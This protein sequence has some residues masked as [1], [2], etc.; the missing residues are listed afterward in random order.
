MCKTAYNLIVWTWKFNQCIF[1]WKHLR[2]SLT[3]N[4]LSQRWVWSCWQLSSAAKSL[5]VSCRSLNLAVCLAGKNSGKVLEKEEVGNNALAYEERII[6]VFEMGGTQRRDTFR[7]WCWGNVSPATCTNLH[8]H[9]KSPATLR[10]NLISAV[11]WS[12]RPPPR[13]RDRSWGSE[14]WHRP[15]NRVRLFA[16]Q[17]FLHHSDPVQRL[18]YH[19]C[20]SRPPRYLNS[21]TWGSSPPCLL[22]WEQ[23]TSEE[24][25][26][27]SRE[28]LHV[29]LKLTLTLHVIHPVMSC[30]TNTHLHAPSWE[31]SWTMKNHFSLR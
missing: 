13:A 4:F 3:Q 26:N 11:C 14:R 7:R 21:L 1:L 29:L 8:P 20:G 6:L 9:T 19:R 18:H 2:L 10:R 25:E 22:E 28:C 24:E 30:P 12:C 27:T 23:P 5:G 31:L 15:V 17:L 16:A